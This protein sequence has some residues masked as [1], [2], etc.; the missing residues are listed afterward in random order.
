MQAH[1]QMARNASIRSNFNPNMSSSTMRKFTMG[2]RASNQVP[3]AGAGQPTA[4]KELWVPSKE[5]VT[6]ADPNVVGS[7]VLTL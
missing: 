1:Q 7:F 5:I 6:F 4:Q 3:P 2:L